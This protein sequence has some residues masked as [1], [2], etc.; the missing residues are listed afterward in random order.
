MFLAILF[1]I[2]TYLIAQTGQMRPL[3]QFLFEKFTRGIV[4][5]K[6]GA[7]YT[8]NLNYNMV[9]EEMIFEQKGTYMSLAKPEEIDT[10]FL[11]NRIFVP[12]E[13]HF[14]EVLSSGAITLYMQHK[15]RYSEPGTP[16]AY[17]I[18]SP[19]NSS[20]KQTVLKGANQFRII[21][22]PENVTIT[23]ASSN[24]ILK[25]GK[26]EKAN[27]ERTFLKLFPEKETELKKFI[28]ENKT[29]FK[30]REDMIKLGNYCNELLRQ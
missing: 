1:F 2:S 12:S 9:D 3:P 24:W 28:K 30:N 20:R 10:V 15:S 11:G 27:N 6:T 13:E 23:P 25:N 29:D 5:S 7:R 19:T 14:N 4:K 21:E 17:G 16:T 22:V 8:A 26:M 18:T